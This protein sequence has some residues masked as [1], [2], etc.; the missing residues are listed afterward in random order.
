MDNVLTTVKNWLK[1]NRPHLSEADIH[2]DEQDGAHDMHFA[3]SPLLPDVTGTHVSSDP[4]SVA[5]VT[6]K[7]TVDGGGEIMKVI[8]LTVKDGAVQQVLES[9]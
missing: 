4:Y 5:T 1:V 7:V 9:K 3:E 8:K 6:D 2:L